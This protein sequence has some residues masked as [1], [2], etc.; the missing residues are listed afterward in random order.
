MKYRTEGDLMAEK[1]NT[2]FRRFETRFG[3]FEIVPT[4][5]VPEGIILGINVDN[6][7]LHP[8]QGMDWTEKEHT[9][10][11]AYIW[12]S[13][14]ARYTLKCLAPET[15]FK[16]YGFDTDLDNYGRVS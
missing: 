3:V 11:G 14:Y 8:Y 5:W 13:I 6:L 9:T 15:M 16:L 12:R 4:R 1:I 10:D 2:V 7:S